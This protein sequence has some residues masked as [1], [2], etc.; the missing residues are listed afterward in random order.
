MPGSR[1]CDDFADAVVAD[2]AFEAAVAAAAAH[3]RVRGLQ[4]HVPDLADQ[5]VLA[6]QDAPVLHQAGAHAA[7]GGKQRHAAL[8]LELPVVQEGASAHLAHVL[9]QDQQAV[10]EEGG[11]LFGDADTESDTTEVT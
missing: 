9:H 5:R 3:L 7:P 4:H 1:F 8:S 6:V 2:L 11:K 10:V